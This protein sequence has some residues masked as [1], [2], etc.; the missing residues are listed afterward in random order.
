VGDPVLAG[1]ESA[2]GYEFENPE[3]LRRALVHRSWEGGVGESNE[4]LEFL[5]DAVLGLVVAEHLFRRGDL[6][7]G[8]M[9][10]TRAAVV[11]AESLAAVAR[12]LDLG[13]HLLLGRGEETTGG[14]GKQSILAD[15]MEAVIGAVFLDG[16]LEPARTLI[17]R[18]WG[19]RLSERAARPGSLDHKT[20]LQEVLAADGK[21]PEYEVEGSGPDHRRVFTAV[22]RSGGRVLGAGEGTSKKRAEQGAAEAALEALGSDA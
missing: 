18:V 22:V 19:R 14:R 3:L 2:L 9:A 12:S 21:V 7:E 6:E 8:A 15:S 10:K 11:N 17:L 1:V 20:R 16:G 13:E 5:G 4:R